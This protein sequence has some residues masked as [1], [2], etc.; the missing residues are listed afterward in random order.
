M[1]N[2]PCKEK[3]KKRKKKGEYLR[4]GGI[5]HLLPR[6]VLKNGWDLMPKDTLKDQVKEHSPFYI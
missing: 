5:L 1:V 3:E 4:M 2:M 6:S